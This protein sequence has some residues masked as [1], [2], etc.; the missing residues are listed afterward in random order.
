MATYRVKSPQPNSVVTIY[1]ALTMACFAY[2]VVGFVLGPIRP[3]GGGENGDFDPSIIKLVLLAVCVP[4]FVAGFIVAHLNIAPMGWDRVPMGG[5]ELAPDRLKGNDSPDTAASFFQKAFPRMLIGMA[6]IESVAII[7]LVFIL[8]D[9]GATIGFSL[10]GLG[11]IGF[12]GIMPR[13][14]YVQ[15]TYAALLKIEREQGDDA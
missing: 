9:L 14:F 2:A 7:G 15:N 13:I 4:Q 5:W 10:I 3:M 6:L 12:A 11:V 1:F 8:L